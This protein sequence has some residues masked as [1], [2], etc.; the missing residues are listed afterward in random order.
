LPAAIRR[1]S[2]GTFERRAVDELRRRDDGGNRGELVDDNVR[3]WLATQHRKQGDRRVVANLLAGGGCAAGRDE[4][5]D[6]PIGNL[7]DGNGEASIGACR[8]LCQPRRR[9]GARGPQ[10]HRGPVDRATGCLHLTFDL[11]GGFSRVGDPAKQSCRDHHRG[12]FTFG[13]AHEHQWPPV[14]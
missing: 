10:G 8:G 13:C 4:I 3:R 7:I 11:D 2:G 9:I 12:C 1:A 5:E 14:K 6:R